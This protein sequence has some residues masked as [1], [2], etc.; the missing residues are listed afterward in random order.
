MESNSCELSEVYNEFMKVKKH[1]EENNSSSLSLSQNEKSI[2][3]LIEHGINK[4]ITPTHHACYL[5]DPRHQG[6]NLKS[7]EEGNAIDLIKLI[8]KHLNNVDMELNSEQESSII[9]LY[10]TL[11]ISKLEVVLF[12]VVHHGQQLTL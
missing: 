1:V 5:L 8:W 11:L 7:E 10:Q 9:Y 2:V 12:K 6:E 4:V 3:E